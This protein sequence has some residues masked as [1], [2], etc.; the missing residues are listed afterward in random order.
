[1]QGG[2]RHLLHFT[3]NPKRIY[4]SAVPGTTLRGTSV[5]STGTAATLQAGT[6]AWVSVVLASVAMILEY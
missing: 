6:T 3:L 2:A 4:D 1:M 5:P